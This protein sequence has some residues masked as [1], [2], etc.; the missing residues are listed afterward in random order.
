M[1]ALPRR[2]FNVLQG[3]YLSL[4]TSLTPSSP[5]SSPTPL[6]PLKSAPTP[7]R[8]PP[9]SGA[10]PPPPPRLV[11]PTTQYPDSCI[12]FIKNLNPS[13]SK[14]ALKELLSHL[15]ST[16]PLSARGK[17]GEVSYV[18]WVKGGDT[19][20]P[21]PPPS[22]LPP[23]P[24]P[25]ASSPSFLPPEL[26]TSL[27]LHDRSLEKAQIR[28]PHRSLSTHLLLT[29]SRSNL[30]H[31]PLTSPSPYLSLTPPTA[32]ARS[33]TGEVFTGEKERLS[34]SGVKENLKLEAVRVAFEWDGRPVPV[35]GEKREFDGGVQG[36]DRKGKKK[37]T[38]K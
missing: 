20:R 8:A 37:K 1:R 27:F 10:R 19:V 11:A 3:E 30:F 5:T 38:V 24:S 13:T 22:P 15:L 4:Q 31:L 26:T 34:W 6:A 33:L 32:D 12:F 23:L 35:D 16:G 21:P 9:P 17:K 25:S 7:Q 36:E 29:L 2:D 18:D 14:T 28:L